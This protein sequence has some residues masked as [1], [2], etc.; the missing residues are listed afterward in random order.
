VYLP[1]IVELFAAGLRY[2]QAGQA[3]Q[4]E[5]L[6]HQVL[7][8]NPRHG[9]ALH[10]LGVIAYQAGRYS[11][12]RD[13]FG[14]A[15]AADP[16]NAGFHSTLGAAYQALG[17]FAEAGS[18]HQQAL[19]LDPK[20]IVA[21][22]NLGI[23]LVSL[24]Q[25]EEAVATFRQALELNP[26]DPEILCNLAAALRGQEKLDEALAYYHEALRLRPDLAQVHHN[27][28]NIL[29]AQGQVDEALACYQRAV[30]AAPRFG[31]AYLSMGQ[32]LQSSGRLDQA[33]LAYRQAVQVQSDYLEG[34]INLGNALLENNCTA[35]ALAAYQ[36]ALRARP[37]SAEAYN[38]LGNAYYAQ[39]QLDEA[40]SCYQSAV[41]L[42][43]DFT[44]PRYNLGV[45]RQAQGR[46][47]EAQ[48]LYQQ[49][50]RQKPDDH[51]AHST[52]LGSLN[53][54]PQVESAVLLAEHRRWAEQHIRR[55]PDPAPHDNPP[56][57]RRRLRVGYAS[58]DFRSHAVAYFLAPILAHHDREQ[59]ES[60]C[61]AD[62][63]AP[64]GMTAHLRAL[65]H[66]WRDTFGLPD[67]KLIHLIRQDRIDILVELVGHTAHNRLLAFARKPAPVQVSYLG[68]PCTTGVPAIDYR[69]GDAIT[70]P[71]G[72]PVYYT[73]EL[74][75]LPN[76]FCCYAAAKNAPR[77]TALPAQARGTLTFGSLHKLDK[78]NAAVLD[79]WCQLLKA[80]PSSRL[81]L[82]RNTLHGQAAEHFRQQFQER[83]IDAARLVFHRV[84]PVN[85]QHL[86]VYDDIDVSLEPFPWDGHTT[87]C[88]SLWMGVP[89]IA[90][91]GQRPSGRMV[92]SVLTA[93]GLTDLIAATPEDYCRIAVR[94]AGDVPQL[95]ELRSGLRQRM[96]E[97]PLCDGA[98]F[99]RGLEDAYRYMWQRWC[100]R[101][102]LHI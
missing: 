92:A 86:R 16:T 41:H 2:H 97:S 48:E 29:Q 101:R 51:V 84:E 38:G 25:K 7:A 82:C 70:D 45:A 76:I 11:A 8:L 77:V 46:L 67:D 3:Q 10:V 30:Q 43:P 83:G 75:R 94:L 52:Y 39:G 57:P 95:A 44:A 78:L 64:D 28:G 81:L 79:L 19:R 62:V 60:I 12:A 88:E 22:N 98:V 18:C 66:Q 36:Q 9:G 90:L 53:Y 47:K 56:D 89:V 49:V 93:L 21:L 59:V 5:P 80:V 35:E 32:A 72:E 4:A 23:T 37:E 61:Y 87:A 13:Y 50:L 26:N 100:D 91:R 42:Q 20:N 69:L 31:L 58:S 99:T 14:Q 63:A 6:L 24:G 33:I 55:G 40:V 73:E 1:T 17:K 85:L 54:D 74:I 96:M 27:L 102:T 15:V 68:Y 71:P 65:A 34:Y